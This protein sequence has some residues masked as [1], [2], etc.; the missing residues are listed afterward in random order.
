MQP[1]D[2]FLA[3]ESG[4]VAISAVKLPENADG[5]NKII[6]RVYETEGVR[7]QAV[8]KFA[9]NVGKAWYVDLNENKTECGVYPQV[10]G[11]IIRFEVGANALASVCIEF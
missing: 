5:G 2:S 4:S 7:T 6:V 11:N 9:R 3:L 10:E 1:A 8:L